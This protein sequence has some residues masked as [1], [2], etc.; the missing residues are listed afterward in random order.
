MRGLGL[1]AL[2]GT[3]LALRLWS[4]GAFWLNPDEGAGYAIAASP[5]W[6]G[7]VASVAAN[8]HP[9]LYYAVLRGLV[10]LG[11]DA[12][13]IRLPGLVAGC[14]AI[15]AFFAGTWRLRGEREAWLAAA[16]AAWAPGLVVLSR[17]ARPY[18]AEV[19]LLAGGSWLLLRHRDTRRRLDGVGA[20]LLLLAGALT[21][22]SA[23]VYLAALGTALVAARALRRLSTAELERLSLPLLPAV[24]GLAALAAIH[25]VPEMLG[26]PTQVGARTRL[27][28]LL[29]HDLAGVWT[30]LVGV[31]DYIFGLRFGA[32][33]TLLSLVGIG[34][35]AWQRR[36]LLPGVALASLGWAA[37][38]SL[39][40]LYPFGASRHSLPLAVVLVPTVATGLCWLVGRRPL[41]VVLAG[42]ALAL[43]AALPGPLHAVLGVQA[44]PIEAETVAPMRTFERQEALLEAAR[45][46]ATILVMDKQTYFM[47]VPLLG[48]LDLGV[49]YPPPDEPVGRIAW[50]PSTL[51]V[52]QTWTLD[53]RP[54]RVHR[55]N[56]LVGLL[57]AADA[58]YPD[59]AL[60]RREDGWLLFGGWGAPA[61]HNLPQLGDR[62]GG[63]PR[64]VD[65]SGRWRADG[66]VHLDIAAC[67][68]AAQRW[69]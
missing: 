38:L 15:P 57:E 45:R 68:E 14:L 27:A 41:R 33:A 11:L 10:G 49:V 25:V 61:Y 22:Y 12:R 50:G 35:L 53:I 2:V 34:S 51:L 21:H 8:A 52:A 44:A 62:L 54:G 60:H 46:E 24:L 69:R 31:H 1:I 67:L 43:L 59:L 23:F 18:L 55:A 7:F 3:G 30:G 36:W 32:L 16:L 65:L 4:I 20:A 9:P 47:L 28:A 5:E 48:P 56:H 26:S 66:S 63:H 37:L 19:A 40:G 17:V 64:C 6:H 39:L 58:T 29:H 13:W 42:T